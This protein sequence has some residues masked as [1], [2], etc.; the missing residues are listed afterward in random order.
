M[1]LIA[2]HYVIAFF[3]LCGLVILVVS[4]VRQS[5]RQKKESKWPVTEGTIQSVGRVYVNA[6]RDS[7]FVDVG[8]FSYNVENEYYSGRLTITPSDSAGD[9]SP[10]VLIHQKLQVHFDPRKPGKF[11]VPQVELM[12]FRLDSYRERFATD[13]EPIDLNIDKV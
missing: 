6:G 2:N 5:V 13:V 3:T 8:D 9:L 11:S 7:Y 4:F 1:E 10:R 12:G